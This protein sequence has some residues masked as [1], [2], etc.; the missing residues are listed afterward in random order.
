MY[1]HGALTI[2]LLSSLVASQSSIRYVLITRAVAEGKEPANYFSRAEKWRFDQV[3]SD[4]EA[5]EKREG[6]GQET[7]EE[8][9]STEKEAE[10]REK[11]KHERA[12][13]RR[14]KV[15]V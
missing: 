2:H 1:V 13:K 10:Q 14:R 3:H 15:A 4:E 9:E 8:M 11:E 5:K 7:L 12:E 6:P